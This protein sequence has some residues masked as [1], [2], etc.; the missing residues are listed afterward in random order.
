MIHNSFS[1]DV[2]KVL[3]DSHNQKDI[4]DHYSKILCTVAVIK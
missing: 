1:V 3:I 4:S 2:G